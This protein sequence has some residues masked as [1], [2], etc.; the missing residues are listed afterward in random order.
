MSTDTIIA[1]DLGRYNSVA[2][3]YDRRTRAHT[4]RTLDTTPDALDRLLA[5][6]KG[7]LVVI[8]ACANAGWV[9]DRAC[10]RGHVV[11]VANTAA[12]AWKFKHLKRKTDRDD[13]LRL[14]QVE[15]PGPLPAARLP[16]PRTRQWC[17]LIALRKKLVGST[18]IP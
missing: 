2:C 18:V 9:H 1:I 15:A 11:K 16:D 12:E 6:H 8:E 10:S 14:A 5:R 13:A 17:Q 4:F 3:V 7:A